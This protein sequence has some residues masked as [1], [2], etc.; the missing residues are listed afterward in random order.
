MVQHVQ[1]NQR[2]ARVLRH[3][4]VSDS[5]THWT[6]C[7]ARLSMGF[8]REEY[9]SGLPFPSPVDLPDSGTELM[10]LVSPTL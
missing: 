7:Q 8:P 4:A 2:D 5:V 9:W 1:I 10:S 6:A 3:S